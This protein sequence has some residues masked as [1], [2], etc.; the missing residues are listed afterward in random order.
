LPYIARKLPQISHIFF[1]K[2]VY[3]LNGGGKTTQ[4]AAVSRPNLP[5]IHERPMKQHYIL[6]SILILLT[7]PAGTALFPEETP[8]P[9]TYPPTA[10]LNAA[11]MGDPALVTLILAANPDPNIRDAFGATALHDALFRANLEVIRLLLEYG[12]DVNAIAPTLG[13]TPLHYAVWLNKPEAIPLLLKYNAD[14]TITN[15]AGQTP[16]QMATKQGKREVLI[17]LSKK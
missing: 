1:I 2:G 6:L 3:L 8:P 13:Y 9:E 12:F 10:I 16:L 17:A 14:K 15:N 4:F 7:F 11:Y 5:I